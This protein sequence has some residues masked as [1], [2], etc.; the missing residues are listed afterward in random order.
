L[1]FLIV[2]LYYALRLHQRFWLSNR[3]PEPQM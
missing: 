2:V 1:F 3:G